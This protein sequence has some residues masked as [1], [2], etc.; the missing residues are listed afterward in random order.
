MRAILRMIV[1]VLR[2]CLKIIW[3]PCS[4]STE[5]TAKIT[6]KSRPVLGSGSAI[7]MYELLST[8]IAIT[9]VASILLL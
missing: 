2:L 1:Q 4:N 5:G 3:R 7:T 9:A 6:T 8:A